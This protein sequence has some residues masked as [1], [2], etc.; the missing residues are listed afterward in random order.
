MA[1]DEDTI[2]SS[3]LYTS[4]CCSDAQTVTMLP[5]WPRPRVQ[6]SRSLASSIATTRT[7]VD[8]PQCTTGTT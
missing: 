6:R 1:G 2:F 3:I 7:T 4:V 5:S 8:L